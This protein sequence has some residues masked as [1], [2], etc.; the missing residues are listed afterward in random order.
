[1]TKIRAL[2]K[3][4]KRVEILDDQLRTNFRQWLE[5]ASKKHSEV[6]EKSSKIILILDGPENFTD[7]NG[8]EQSADWIPL[9]FPEKFKVIILAR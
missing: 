9:S 7:E 6:M 1:M 8:I 3:I 4:D 5:M 2:Y